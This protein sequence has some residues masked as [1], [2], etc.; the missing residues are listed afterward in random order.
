MLSPIDWLKQRRQP[1][2]AVQIS[3]EE[4]LSERRGTALPAEIEMQGGPLGLTTPVETRKETSFSVR[5]RAARIQA[6]DEPGRWQKIWDER[7]KADQKKYNY[8]F[9]DLPWDEVKELKIRIPPAR[10][11]D[12]KAGD[13]SNWSDW[14]P[15]DKALLTPYQSS[16]ISKYVR[17][18]QSKAGIEKG[19]ETAMKPLAHIPFVGDAVSSAAESIKKGPIGALI[20]TIVAGDKLSLQGII[21]EETLRGALMPVKRISDI[22]TKGERASIGELAGVEEGEMP[23]GVEI[24]GQLARLGL[25]FTTPGKASAAVMNVAKATVGIE[26]VELLQKTNK[27]IRGYEQ[28]LAGERTAHTA[29]DPGLKSI[30]IESRLEALKGIQKTLQDRIS[31]GLGRR[32]RAALRSAGEKAK[33]G[34]KGAAEGYAEGMGMS[35]KAPVQTAPAIGYEYSGGSAVPMGKRIKEAGG[36]SIDT[37]KDFTDVTAVKKNYGKNIINKDARGID[38]LATLLIEE[39]YYPEGMDYKAVLDDIKERAVNGTLDEVG[40]TFDFGSMT[41]QEFEAYDKLRAALGREPTMKELKSAT[42]KRGRKPRPT[43]TK[44]EQAEAAKRKIELNEWAKEKAEGRAGKVKVEG[45]G[46]VKVEAEAEGSGGELQAV[47]DEARANVAAARKREQVGQI[48]ELLGRSDLSPD[49][50]ATAEANKQRLQAEVGDAG[51]GGPPK[52][53]PIETRAAAPDD[54]IPGPDGPTRP[55][56]LAET[57]AEARAVAAAGKTLSPNVIDPSA[58]ALARQEKI[59]KLMK[60]WTTKFREVIEDRYIRI[61]RLFDDQDALVRAGRDPY[62][63]YRVHSGRVGARIENFGK[64]ADEVKLDIINSARGKK[65]QEI[66]EVEVERVVNGRKMRVKQQVKGA[67]RELT[68]DDLADQ[69]SAYLEAKHAPERNAVHYDGASGLTDAEATAVMNELKASPHFKEIERLAG[70]VREIDQATLNIY[71]DYGLISEEFYGKLNEMYPNHVPLNRIFPHDEWGN[72]EEILKATARRKP[73][74]EMAVPGS[75]VKKAIGSRAERE[76]VIYNVIANHEA[77]IIRAEKNLVGNRTLEYAQSAEGKQLGFIK[78]LTPDEAMNMGFYDVVDLA[79]KD[80]K[81]AIVRDVESGKILEVPKKELRDYASGAKFYEDAAGVERKVELVTQGKSGNIAKALKD[82]RIKARVIPT[83]VNGELKH[84]YIPD[85]ALAMA[86]RGMDMAELP[87]VIKQWAW[88]TRTYAGLMT[89]FNP[90]FAIPNKLRDM[91]ETL[92]YLMSEKEYGL[93][94]ALKMASKDAGSIKA[95]WDWKAGRQTEGARM[96]EQMRMDGGA[97]G[98]M[99]LST[100]KETSINLK[101]FARM[102]QNNPKKAAVWL[103]DK[104]D[105]FNGLFEDSTRLSIYRQALEAGMTRERAAYLARHASIDFKKMGTA[106]PVINGLWM[107][108][109]AS[110]QGSAK[111]IKAINPVKHP[112]VASTV[113]GALLTA[114]Y[115]ASSYN[116]RMDP[117]WEEKVLPWDMRRGLVIVTGSGEDFNYFV[118]PCSWGL[119][120]LNVGARALVNWHLSGKADAKKLAGEMALSLTESYNPMNSEDIMT[121]ATPT[122]LRPGWE[123]RSNK[124]WTG[125]QIRPERK[126]WWQGR[127]V[128]VPQHLQYYDRLADTVMGRAMIKSAETAADWGVEVS[129]QDI[130]YAF[131][132]LR[133][134]TGTF[135]T[136]VFDSAMAIVKG[137]SPAIKDVPIASRFFRTIEGEGQGKP[138]VLSP[139]EWLK[140]RRQKMSPEEWLK[141]RRKAE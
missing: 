66:Q 20:D 69:V 79:K 86:M 124:G 100:R 131:R 129:P 81:I 94:N 118:V 5:Q 25:D 31:N 28:M 1:A 2:A 58:P 127:Q 78:E 96:Y 16:Y 4:W 138:K 135:V 34:V 36:F 91:Q 126:A 119:A 46:K 49:Q 60:R 116:Y 55:I 108:S 136:K 87:I 9:P 97:M 117:D 88:L 50:R 7:V 90:E 83:M 107:F 92:V 98:G 61:K 56:P 75:G 17:E 57:A 73:K 70:R 44:A 123:I 67:E 15:G 89:R 121:A 63:I 104:V 51:Q 77:A 22:I 125:K 38:D 110:I 10:Q 64:Q 102:K 32:I 45:G 106:G 84:I 134:G 8:S 14:S 111:M 11:E 62:T 30:A 72:V 26:K 120:P 24:I 112:F 114:N 93:R 103:I 130:D 48:D 132:Q 76:D 141:Q 6:A 39:G 40:R 47:F 109:N 115:A 52:R 27:L 35:G 99:A 101:E 13:T 128:K 23:V 12:I 19:F 95:I 33:A 137:E 37:A 3:P 140:Q 80:P 71:R 42:S 29:A 133:G 82:E 68:G 122:M 21:N 65:L 54:P 105:D 18:K 74:N 59:T 41:R 139:E 85:A 113:S 53:P 43:E